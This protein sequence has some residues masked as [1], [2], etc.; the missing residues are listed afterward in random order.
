MPRLQRITGLSSLDQLIVGMLVLYLF[1][2]AFELSL[3]L[4][5]GGWENLDTCDHSSAE[6]ARAAWQGY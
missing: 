5:C 4:P 2:F 1:V 6:A 3:V